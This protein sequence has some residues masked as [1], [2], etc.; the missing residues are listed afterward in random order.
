MPDRARPHTLGALQALTTVGNILAAV[1]LGYVVPSEKLGWGWRGLY[2]LG[3]LPGLIAVFVFWRLREPA[4]W[5]TAKAAAEKTNEGEQFGRL[6]S[7]FTQPQWRRHALVGLGLAVAGQIGL[8][9]VAFYT[10]ELIDSAIPTVE[11]NLR[12]KLEAI[13]RSSS[14]DAHAA[15]IKALDGKEQRKYAELVS[16]VTGRKEKIEAAQL[17][18]SPL[19]A[20]EKEKLRA[21]AETAITEDEKT[22][23]KSKAGFLQQIGSFFGIFCFTFMTARLGRRTSFFIALI[24]AWASLFLAFAT[25]HQP[26]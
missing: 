20:I 12:P 22:S 5:V 17:F 18:A 24:L 21:L 4:R 11:K 14:P 26:A 9:G 7:L 23:L 8:W 15:G 2:Y 19:T 3:A 13:L 10:P 6:S 25:F 1:S 16:R